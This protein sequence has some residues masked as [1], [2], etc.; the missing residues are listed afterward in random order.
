[1]NPQVQLDKDILA[2]FCRKWHI[3]ELSLFGSAL[4]DDFGPDSD[5][6]FLVSFE[7]ETRLDLFDLIEMREEL[8]KTFGRPVDLVE[9]EAIRN[10]WRR[11]EILR[12]R[13]VLYAA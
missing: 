6:D 10:P 1:M 5:L 13:E 4:R 12:T 2:A 9:K 7:P 11:Y 3:R 8:A